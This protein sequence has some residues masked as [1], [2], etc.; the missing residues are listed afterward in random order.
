MN[1]LVCKKN[2][3]FVTYKYVPFSVKSY[4]VIA[5]KFGALTEV[6][7]CKI[8]NFHLSFLRIHI[9]NT[10]IKR[11]SLLRKRKS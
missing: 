9:S 8:N 4:T 5:P 2:L 7:T 10:D 11:L 6:L 3:K 1:E